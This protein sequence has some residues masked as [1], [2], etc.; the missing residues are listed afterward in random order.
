MPLDKGV[1]LY[2]AFLQYLDS[3][4]K[5]SSLTGYAGP[6]NYGKIHIVCEMEECTI[7]FNFVTLVCVFG[8]FVHVPYVGLQKRESDALDTDWHYR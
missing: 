5:S 2:L 7:L 8:C 1:M 4:F 6:V 3:R